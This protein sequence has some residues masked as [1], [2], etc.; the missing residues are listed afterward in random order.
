[1][2]E[3]ED[4]PY[5]G[6]EGFPAERGLYSTVLEVSGLHRRHK[7]GAHRFCAPTE[8]LKGT[9]APFKPIWEAVGALLA[10]A[11]DPIPLSRLYRAW[12]APPYGL[13]RGVL[14]ILAVAY[15]LANRSSLA[16]YAEGTFRPELDRYA[17]D[18]LLQDENPIALRPV[19]LAGEKTRLLRGLAR[20][21]AAVA[22]ATPEPEPLPVAR[23]LVRFV[24]QLPVWT[25]KTTA[26]P[27]SALA[28]RKVLLSASDP[29]RALFV[30]LPVQLE[31][32]AEAEIA[33]TIAN[34]LAA[35]AEAYPRMLRGLRDRMFGALSHQN[36]DLDALQQR[37]RVVAGMS[38]DLRLD[39]FATRLV[40]FDGTTEAM[41][42]I[43]QHGAQ[44]AAVRLV[45][46]RS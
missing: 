16:L 22:D 18:L 41:E 6:I 40:A 7:D 4:A 43:A 42:G 14:P 33:S 28:V 2:V 23:A 5:L 21:V 13:R 1:M 35:L 20:A 37:A 15:I 3:H 8:R 25:R 19:D 29:H 38:G 24:F 36:G 45:R 12:S 32:T 39:A 11:E 10:G 44:Q 26:L 30:D 46:S 27:E 17:V 9:G 31:A 34:A